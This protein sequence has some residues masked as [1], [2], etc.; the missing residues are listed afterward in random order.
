MTTVTGAD[1]ENRR[2]ATMLL[3]LVRT[4][5]LV[6]LLAAIASLF[7]P[8]SDVTIVAGFYGPILAALLG[9]AALLRRGLVVVG[10]WITSI[11]FWLVIAVV[12]LF[13]CG[14]QGQNAATFAVSVLLIGV[15]VGGRAALMLAVGSSL[16][17]GLVAAL[18]L[19]GHL[20][21][22]LGQYSPISAWIA[23]TVMLILTGFLLHCSLDS[24]QRMHGREQAAA[25]DRD[26]ALRRSIQA[27][28]LE[29]VGT[30]ASGIAH[31][32]NNLLTVISGAAGVLRDNVEPTAENTEVLDDLDTATAR[33]ALMTKQ[34]LAF[35]RPPAT[36]LVPVDLGSLVLASK[37]ML[38]RLLGS[39][40][41]VETDTE[42]GCTLMADPAGLEQILLNLA[43]NARDAMPTGGVLRLVVRRD[44]VGEV[45][46]SASDTG[47][48]IAA[49]ILERI[50]DPFFTTKSN[51]TGLGL[52][53]VRDR[54]TQF[55]GSVSVVS[56]V[57][58]G[59]TFTLRFPSVVANTGEV[60]RPATVV[61]HSQ[62]SNRPRVLLAKDD[63][64]V[65][66]A[67]G[68]L[69]ETLGFEVAAVADGAEALGLLDAGAGFACVVTDV[70]MPRMDGEA[71]ASTM[72]QRHPQIPVVL[73]SGNADPVGLAGPGRAFVAKPIDP[74]QL[75]RAIDRLLA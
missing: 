58:Q 42:P 70:M 7:D 43:V 44:P 38:P 66:R 57:D 62:D 23:V 32:F 17:C 39:S 51:G 31:D 5:A 73:V 27:Q 52:A 59:T 21:P 40:I 48:G 30:L 61:S 47:V 22:Q 53:T 72:A 35:G 8:I 19:S 1:E 64:L 33:A 20:P 60:V 49:P 16:W 3:G 12:T 26:Q 69:L 41:R 36:R 46:L 9:I 24:L 6:A 2:K 55:S 4:M 54:V 18:E 65:R 56:V 45:V 34:L 25:R 14:L 10:A 68:R 75:S 28:K 67:T 50:F 63:P 74:D 11:F 29:V 71:L 15:V 37:A 13:F